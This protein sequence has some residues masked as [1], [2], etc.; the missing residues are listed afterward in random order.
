MRVDVG[1][2]YTVGCI[3][4]THWVVD[5]CVI[6]GIVIRSGDIVRIVIGIDYHIRVDRYFVN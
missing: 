3:V 6:V 4:M 5:C 1:I 2:M